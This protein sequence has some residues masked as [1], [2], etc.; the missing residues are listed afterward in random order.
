MVYAD[1]TEYGTGWAGVIRDGGITI[2]EDT[3]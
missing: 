2:S 1:L 3:P